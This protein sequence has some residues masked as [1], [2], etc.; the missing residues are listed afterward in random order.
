MWIA[1]WHTFTNGAHTNACNQWN[2]LFINRNHCQ[3]KPFVNRH[4][5]NNSGKCFE[6]KIKYPLEN[7]SHDVFEAIFVIY[8]QWVRRSG[9]MVDC[10]EF[11]PS[12][13]SNIFEAKIFESLI[14]LCAVFPI[15]IYSVLRMPSS[16]YFV[17]YIIPTSFFLLISRTWSFSMKFDNFLIFLPSFYDSVALFVCLPSHV[18]YDNFFHSGGDIKLLLIQPKSSSFC[19][20]NAAQCR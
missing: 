20:E 14:W 2:Y 19:L 11:P 3:P 5:F 1:R 6:K 4:S 17:L 16:F 13:E 7:F 12:I 8:L 9:T 18:F 10:G 15:R